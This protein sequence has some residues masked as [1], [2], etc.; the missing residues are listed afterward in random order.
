MYAIAIDGPAGAGKSTVS[1]VV[2]KEIG[3]LY[4]DTGALY[5]AVAYSVLQNKIE[6]TDSKAVCALLPHMEVRLGY[7]DGEQQVYLNKENVTDMLR[8]PGFRQQP[9]PFPPLDQY[10]SFYFPSRRILPGK[11]IS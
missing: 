3:F 8:T 11:I 10:G 1:R 7:E 2:A 6:P 5:R 4:V 9:L